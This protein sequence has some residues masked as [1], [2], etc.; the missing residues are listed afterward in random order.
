[1]GSKDSE[2]PG[3][4]SIWYM[5]PETDVEE[6]EDS[7]FKAQKRT[8]YTVNILKAFKPPKNM[9]QKRR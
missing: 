5:E 9:P 1:M 7:S 2:E 4:G 8:V 3:E 6:A